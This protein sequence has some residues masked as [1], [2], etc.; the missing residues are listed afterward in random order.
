MEPIKADLVVLGAGPGGYAAAFYAADLG[1]KVILVE[2][3]SRLGGVCMNRGCIPSKALLYATGLIGEARASGE[4]GI[5]FSDPEIDT[6]KLRS[7]KDS[8]IHKLATGVGALADRRGVEVLTGRGHFESSGV[9]RVE[10]EGGQQFVE[11]ENVIVAVGSRPSI[12]K[13]WDLGNRRVMTSTEALEVEMIPESL[14]VIGGGYIG[15]EMGTVYAALGSR[16]VVVEAL[17]SILQGIDSDLVRPVLRYAK[18]HFDEL[19]IQTE[20]RKLA[21]KGKQIEVSTKDADGE[22]TE[23]YDRVLIAVGRQPNSDDLGLGNT[24]VELDERGFIRV[25]GQQRTADSN[26]FA[27]GDVAGGVLLAHKA[28]KEARVAVEALVGESSLFEAVIPAVVFT[29]PEVAWCGLTQSEALDRGIAVEVAKF[30]WAAS[31]RAIS[32]DKPDGMTKLVVEPETERILGMGIVGVGAG[33]LISEGVALIEM[34]GTARDLAET[35]HPHPTLSETLMEAAE[36]FYG[37]ATHA[38]SRQKRKR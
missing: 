27:I 12:P 4:R 14:L 11:F 23:L 15:M 17:D 34:G 32:V 24:K 29:H 10:T 25:D 21:T 9:L 26:I 33:E 30:P 22:A 18:E 20:V 38:T 28:S 7:W 2:K 16:V 36:M 13:A 37:H 19:R 6:A 8:V 3:E 1:K 35:V 5:A 31:G